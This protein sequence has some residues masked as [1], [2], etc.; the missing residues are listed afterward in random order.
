MWQTIK[1]NWAQVTVLGAV[2]VILAGAYMEWRI[3]TNVSAGLAAAGI[4]PESDIVAIE[5]DIDDLE[6]ADVRMDS[7]IERI[8]DILLED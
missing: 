4:V 8:V 6:K 3:A 2:V 1:D 7:K 5:E